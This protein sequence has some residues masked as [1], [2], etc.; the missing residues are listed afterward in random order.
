MYKINSK[1]APTYLQELFPDR[2]DLYNLRTNDTF[3]IPCFQTM[4]YGKKSFQYYGSELL[5]HIPSNIRSKVPLS[6]FKSAV[7]SWLNSQNNANINF[8]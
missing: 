2:E 7:T 3:H 5:M 1:T 6:S 8:L 4:T